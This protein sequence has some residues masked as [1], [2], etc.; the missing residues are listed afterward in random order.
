MRG[1]T[2]LVG[3]QV[4]ALVALLAWI[5]PTLTV[6]S[7][8]ERDRRPRLAVIIVVDQFR[9]DYL[10]RF[11]SNFT[12]GLERLLADG[13]VF[14][15]ANFEQWPTVT[16]VGHAT[17]ATGATPSGHG[18]V[19]ND[20]YDRGDRRAVTSVD[21]PKAPRVPEGAS[22]A[23][24]WRLRGTTIGDELKLATR[25]R[26]KVVSV[27]IKARSAVLMGGHRPDT[28][29]WFD[30]GL[31]SFVSSRHYGSQLPAWVERLNAS[32][33]ADRFFAMKWGLLLP[34][35]AYAPSDPYETPNEAPAWGSRG[36]P[37]ALAEGIE[38]PNSKFYA[39]VT[40]SP[41]GNDLVA[42]A[43]RAAVEGERLGADEV[44]DLLCLSF[45]SNDLVGHAYGPYSR[46]VEDITLRTDRLIGELL[47]FLDERVGRG[48]Y[49]VALTADHGVA[50]TPS[51]AT[52]L[53]GRY[54]K[55]EPAGPG[56][57]R[58]LEARFGKGPWV[59]HVSSYTGIYLNRDLASARGVD[60]A[61]LERAAAAEMS[62]LP[63]VRAVY[64]ASEL[65]A[66]GRADGTIMSRRV[67]VSHFPGRSPDVVVIFE[68]FVVT[69][70]P[71]GTTH[72][73][74]YNYDA[75]VPLV[76][77]GF[78]VAGGVVTDPVAIADLA[79]TLTTVLGVVP[80]SNAT[81]RPLRLK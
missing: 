12:G 67:S 16:A 28:A 17:V 49:V 42:A 8:Q 18:I 4:L 66:G 5:A 34:E 69:S 45:S 68:P 30:D 31:G 27:S 2:R 61:E 46:E 29:V 13:R 53:G 37:K 11:R 23:S 63:G 75:H 33:P 65:A 14:V 57:E 81:G 48:R 41:Y 80:P 1:R 55:L 51:D 19:G 22:G 74:P 62:R 36:F 40:E 21:D 77:Y 32:R 39:R 44:P 60:V 43:A 54:A 64:T 73:T 35:N 3:L 7:R 76:F 79:P 26:A 20:W 9:A 58:A 24:P 78:G 50:P 15:N 25:N 70:S 10:V 72:G 47:D 52:N 59:L 56:L 38:G 6:A 71:G